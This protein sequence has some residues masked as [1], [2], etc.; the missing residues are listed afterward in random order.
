[1][2][3]LESLSREELLEIVASQQRTIEEQ[4]RLIAE[5]RD[6]IEQLR[7]GGK[8]QAAPFSKEKRV[9]SPK[10]PGRKPGQGSFTR[11]AA[12]VQESTKT[13]AVPAPANC[14]DCGGTLE[15]EREE[16]ATT[17]DLPNQPQP[18]VT[19][20]RVPVCRCRQCGK[21]VRGTAPGLAGDQAG[22]TAH[23][24]GPRAM[25][26]AHALHYA[27]GIPVRK[28]P[29]VLHELT[30][31]S[32]T[33]SAI[34]QDAMRRAE[35]ALGTAYRGLRDRVP[36]AP[37]VHTDDTGWRVSGQT[38]FLMGFDTDGATVYQIRGQHRN[39]EVR[40]IIPSD[41]G[42]VMV[43]DRG[44][45]YDAEEF[46]GVAQ[47]KCLAHLLRNIREV[48]DKKQGAARRFGETSMSLLREGL[49]LWHARGG[50]DAVQ[51]Q[52]RAEKLGQELTRHLRHR[53]LRDGDNQRLLDGIGWQHDRGHL[54]RFLETEGVEPT[55]NRAERILR[56]AVIARKVSHCSRNQRGAA[57]F[58]IFVSLAQTAR[59]KTQ[60]TGRTVSQ[61]LLSLFAPVA[62]V[63]SR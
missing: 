3:G 12:P 56:P 20:Y 17:A 37:A 16:V 27:I 53:L 29:A 57:A 60:G 23:R 26:A 44:K 38:A 39:E 43:T 62:P 41:Y 15:Q 1:M 7:R 28:V 5:L 63:D 42:G 22:A 34:T 49:A 32:L 36:E 61:V 6:E 58:A 31:I 24:V 30:G 35:G 21:R 13:V 40:E 14:P 9:E 18:L 52:N 25:A 51:F 55:N 48:V 10:S 19:A 46:A 47:Q 11:R 50:F 4:Q 33:Q 54:L 59:K 8:R 45:S 2:A